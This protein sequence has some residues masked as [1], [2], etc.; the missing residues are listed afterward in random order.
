MIGA[1]EKEKFKIWQTDRLVVVLVWSAWYHSGTTVVTGLSRRAACRLMRA[2][3]CQCQGG[4]RSP[5]T[6]QSSPVWG[7]GGG[8]FCALGSGSLSAR[9]T[10]EKLL[11]LAGGGHCWRGTQ[12]VLV[13]VGMWVYVGGEGGNT[14]TPTLTNSSNWEIKQFIFI[15]SRKIKGS[16]VM[17]L[18]KQR[19]SRGKRD[20]EFSNLFLLPI[21]CAAQLAG[22][23]E[24]LMKIQIFTVILPGIIK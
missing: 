3:Q 12:A 8:V 20:V 17:S 13:V 9:E 15:L 10:E 22:I 2:S 1:R 24:Q 19:R 14:T 21:R 4:S 16:Q 23:M 7:G 6:R 18:V 11:N 5:G